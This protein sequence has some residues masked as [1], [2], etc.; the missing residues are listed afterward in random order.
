MIAALIRWFNQFLCSHPNAS[1]TDGE[2][3]CTKCRAIWPAGP[4]SN[5]I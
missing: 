4:D 1:L 3:Q 5:D 2:W